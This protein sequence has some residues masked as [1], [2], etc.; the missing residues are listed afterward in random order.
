MD[1]I[2][3]LADPYGVSNAFTGNKNLFDSWLGPLPNTGRT[4]PFE[5]RAV[6]KW[7]MPDGYVGQNQYLGQSILD[8]LFLNNN[9]I[10]QRIMPLRETNQITLVWEQFEA[11]AHML[12]TTPYQTPAHLLTQRRSIRRARL[13]HRNI[14]VEFEQNFLQTPMGRVSF[15][16]AMRQ[17]ENSVVQTAVAEGIRS[18]L[19]CHR[20]Q[21]QFRRE[22]MGISVIDIQDALKRD[23]ENFAIVQK[24]KNG[25]TKLDLDISK[26]MAS[27]GG[28][29]NAYLVPEEVSIY[30]QSVPSTATD[31]DK[32]GFMG[33]ARINGTG[34]NQPGA[35]GTAKNVEPTYLVR[36]NN[37]YVVKDLRVEGVS[38][39]DAEM[40]TRV[41]Q[42]GEFMVMAYDPQMDATKY[43]SKHRSILAYDEDIDDMRELTIQDAIKNCGLFD[44][45]G[46]LLPISFNDANTRGLERQQDMFVQ[47]RTADRTPYLTRYLF[48]MSPEYLSTAVIVNAAKVLKEKGGNAQD[49]IGSDS[50]MGSRTTYVDF[51]EAEFDNAPDRQDVLLERS[52]PRP[53]PN[54]RNMD[55][56]IR[57]DSAFLKAMV[58]GGPASKQVELNAIAAQTEIP[59]L[60]RSEKIR[61]RIGQYITEKVKGI[62]FP[63]AEKLAAWH[64]MLVSNH[65]EKIAAIPRAPVAPVQRQ[66]SSGGL[67]SIPAFAEFYKVG[68]QQQSQSSQQYLSESAGGIGL[69]E[70]GQFAWA[71]STTDEGMQGV[72]NKKLESFT[73]RKSALEAHYNAV[74]ADLKPYALAFLMMRITMKNLLNLADKDIP[75]F[76]NFLL[77]RPHQQ[78]ATKTV[79]KCQQ[80]GGTGYT[81][82]GMANFQIEHEAGRM[83]ALAHYSTHMRSVVMQPKNAWVQP[84]VM[85]VRTEGG[86]GCKFWTPDA[87]RARNQVDEDHIEFSLICV[88][89]PATE[90]EFPSPM[91]ITG[92]FNTLYSNQTS[93]NKQYEPL[94]YSTAARYRELY[95]FDAGKGSVSDAPITGQRMHNNTICHQG[96]QQNYNP[97]TS[98]FDVIIVNKGHWGKNVYPGVRDEV[99]NGGR[100]ELQHMNYTTTASN[101]Y[102]TQ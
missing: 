80:D 63:D 68:S 28:I 76:F 86:A 42:I 36:N 33:P 24:V 21:E 93:G 84:D 57:W 19:N 7:N 35:A 37:T 34:P 92:R 59:I 64:S 97:G 31:Y 74:P 66:Y 16:A 45:N 44:D 60:V 102:Y 94:H 17:I 43:R 82:I 87:Y 51:T 39:E 6:D 52:G 73:D 81:F 26:E 101:A 2:V 10:I 48:Q 89:T 14:M 90:R 41:R 46:E 91:D 13:V 78:V 3:A 5:T 67:E 79:I 49:M 47:F 69:A 100:H 1:T 20:Y 25:M 88:A 50:F 99:R 23:R 98:K 12:D 96:H 53:I 83:L 70:I 22:H 27:Y 40:L 58:S 71:R 30:C 38:R 65:Q 54:P 4:D 55:E 32:A 11:M 9:F 75:V 85:V 62:M 56:Q 72:I 15:M 61:D 95:R 29:A 8:L 18:L 77:L